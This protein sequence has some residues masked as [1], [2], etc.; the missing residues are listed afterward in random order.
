MAWGRLSSC[1][2]FRSQYQLDQPMPFVL[3]TVFASLLLP[4]RATY[5]LSCVYLYQS[6]TLFR[7]VLSL[8]PVLVPLWLVFIV[9]LLMIVFR[10]VYDFLSMLYFPCQESPLISAAIG[11]SCLNKF[12]HIQI[13][14]SSDASV[15]RL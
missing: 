2:S 9:S 10:L 5:P 14:K 7:L 11:Q 3:D 15:S 4:L 8:V 6:G 12:S 1:H 13:Q